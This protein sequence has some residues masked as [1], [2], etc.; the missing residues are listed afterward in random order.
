MKNLLAAAA[1]FFLLSF[2]AFSQQ[3]DRF[4]SVTEKT[5]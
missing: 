5:R 2:S 4:C 3:S 1:V